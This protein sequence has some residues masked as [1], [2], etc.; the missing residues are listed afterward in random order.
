MIT[1]TNDS[2]EVND[3][4]INNFAVPPCTKTVEYSIVG[5]KSKVSTIVLQKTC[6]PID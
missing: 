1:N 4:Y 6:K 2:T 3:N 5:I